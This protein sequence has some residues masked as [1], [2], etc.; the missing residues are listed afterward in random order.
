MIRGTGSS[1]RVECLVEVVIVRRAP[2]S[3]ASRASRPTPGARRL[4]GQAITKYFKIGE[5]V[6]QVAVNPFGKE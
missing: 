2:A 5:W 3:R 1:R 6:R 4:A